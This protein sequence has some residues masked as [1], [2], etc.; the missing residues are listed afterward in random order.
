MID[1]KY[2]INFDLVQFRKRK[3]GMLTRDINKKIFALDTETL[4]GYCKLLADSK[5]NYV[6]SDIE[7]ES[8]SDIDM[9]LNF[10]TAHRFRSAHNFFFNL[11]YDVNAIIK[12]LPKENLEQLYDNT[13]TTY[14]DIDI[15]F[16]P[17]K[18][19]SLSK[20]KNVYKYYD[21]AQFYKTSLE[22]A[23]KK[24]LGLEKYI[25]MLSREKIGTSRDYWRKRYYSI[26]RYCI[27]DCKLTAQLGELLYK[28]LVDNVGLKPNAFISKASITKEF[29]RKT[30]DYPNINDIPRNAL[31]YAFYSYGG[32]RF[33]VFEKG[34]VG[35][36][37]LYDIN[38]AY[39]DTMRNLLDVTKGKWERVN[40]MHENADYGFYLAEV[41][42]K[43]NRI[44]PIGYKTEGIVTYPI[45]KFSMYITKDELLAYEKFID[46]EIICGW[47]FFADEYVYPFRDYIMKLYK[48]KNT[49]DDKDFAY[50]CSKILMNGGY[51]LTWEKKISKLINPR[52]CTKKEWEIFKDCEKIS[53]LAGKL[54]N[55][56]YATMITA[57]TRINLFKTCIPFFKDTVAFA[58]DSV[59]FK[60]GVEIPISK[61]LG[62]WDLVMNDK[63]VV[64]KGGIYKIG[65]KIKNRG[66]KSMGYVNTPFGKYG[67]IFDYIQKQPQLTEYKI[68]S[69]RPLTFVEVLLHHLK[70]NIED[71]NVFTEMEYTIDLNKDH[72]R[73]WND[74]FE[75]GS[76]LFEK[77]IDSLPLILA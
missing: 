63:T 17:K 16:I 46:Y 30:I 33:E 20:G 32:G 57:K 26:I 73:I 72:K 44:S 37:V 45:A 58:T 41:Y 56:V 67:T 10:L 54:F 36:C 25:E 1:V 64:L 65:D 3:V 59:L 70:H 6:I 29:M 61:E 18:L 39:P 74:T 68:I 42:V 52:T 51:G 31:K 5:G 69:K 14:N 21:V 43:Y 28:T 35:D 12:Y 48:W 50:D 9:F 62:D 8:N 38:S 77:S 2:P 40:C 11:N 66:I 75:N 71:I 7:Q 24:Y 27:N 15:F 13:Q 55:P 53:I 22:K 47:E 49:L 19:L 23:S 60:N 76:Q 34:F 4:H